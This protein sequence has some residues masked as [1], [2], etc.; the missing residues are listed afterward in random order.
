MIVY[1]LGPSCSGKSTFVAEHSRPGDVTVDFDALAQCLGATREHD[2]EPGPLKAAFAARQA[3][4][5]AIEDGLPNDQWVIRSTLQPEAIQRMGEAGI[6]FVV[7]DPGE[8][9]ALER[10]A[11]D[12]R[13]EGTA[14][15][16]RAWYEDPPQVP[17]EF[18]WHE[19]DEP[20]GARMQIKSLEVPIKAAPD[21]QPG[22][23]TGYASVFGNKDSYGDVI[24][25]GAF[26]ESLK[27][28]GAQ[29]E[30]IAC[31][32]SHQMDDPSKCIGWTTKAV[33]D[34]HGLLV[35]VK[36]D[37][38]NP[39]AAQ[40]HRL[41]KAGVVNQMSFAYEVQDYAYAESEELGQHVELRALKIFEVSVVQVGANQ[42]TELL[43]VKTQ[44][45]G[46]KAGRKLSASNEDKLT[47][48]VGLINEVLND[49]ADAPDDDDAENSDEEQD[50]AKAEEPET[51]N[52]EERTPAKSRTFTAVDIAA[53][54]L[55]LMEGAN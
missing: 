13:P 5:G 12:D 29:G 52:A 42:E 51:A 9:E 2:P 24:I 48:A 49:G 26:T 27:D 30:G 53:I 55:E 34:D 1:V 28:Y 35:E 31:Y 45:M 38:E 14:D 3:V 46:L 41:I 39:V 10:C 4:E 23:F 19:N 6:R 50:D 25:P 16:I 21:A 40:V 15:R 7:C 8:D 37:L 20:K 44:L 33:E 18:L 54:E 17:D 36:L 47:Q 11:A 43:D 22:S 32:W